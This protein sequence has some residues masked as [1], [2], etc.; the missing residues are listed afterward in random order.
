MLIKKA[1]EQAKVS[2]ELEGNYVTAELK[3]LVEK[4]IRKEITDAEFKKRVLE[5]VKKNV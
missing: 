1:L 3:E 5:L 4:V 2:I